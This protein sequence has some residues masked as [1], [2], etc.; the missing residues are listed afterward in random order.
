MDIFV[1]VYRKIIATVVIEIKQPI[2]IEVAANIFGYRSNSELSGYDGN[3][4]G[5]SPSDIAKNIT[6]RVGLIFSVCN[7]CKCVENCV[8][9]D[10]V[11]E[12]G[13]PYSYLAAVEYL[14]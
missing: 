2:F 1:C 8:S 7:I 11:T 3:S 10:K 13:T 6:R 9:Q 14:V 12:E 4:Y 5:T